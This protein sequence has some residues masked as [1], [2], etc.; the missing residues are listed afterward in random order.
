M[1][2][3]IFTTYTLIFKLM[4]DDRYYLTFNNLSMFN[5][6]YKFNAIE[7]VNNINFIGEDRI[8]IDISGEFFNNIV[9]NVLTIFSETFGPR[10]ICEIYC[11][12]R[13]LYK[14]ESLHN[15][16]MDEF[17]N[18]LYKV[19]KNEKKQKYLDIPIG[20]YVNKRNNILDKF[21]RLG[22]YCA[23]VRCDICPFMKLRKNLNINYPDI[24]PIPCS[25]IENDNLCDWVKFV[26]DYDLESDKKGM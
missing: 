22:E 21:G 1:K 8:Y 2:P 12:N 4:V 11:E 9:A 18:W 3:D 25:S 15:E 17:K 13:I 20:I 19:V 23:G 10:F 16:R 6:F 14:L 24:I 5:M 26:M 7:G